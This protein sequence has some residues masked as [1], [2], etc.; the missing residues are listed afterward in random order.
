MNKN[1]TQIHLFL[2]GVIA[3]Y[4]EDKSWVLISTLFFFFFQSFMFVWDASENQADPKGTS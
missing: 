2:V 3:I 4:F 1:K